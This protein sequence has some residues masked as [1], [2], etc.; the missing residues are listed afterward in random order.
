MGLKLTRKTGQAVVLL[1]DGQELARITPNV[2]PH[3]SSVGLYITAPREIT[4]MRAE[5]LEKEK[6]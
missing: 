3:S 5:L 4:I 1:K 6:P 2:E